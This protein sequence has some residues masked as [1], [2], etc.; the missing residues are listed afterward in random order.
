M[1]FNNTQEPD[2]WTSTIQNSTGAEAT[3]NFPLSELFP[4]IV[5]TSFQALGYKKNLK[6]THHRFLFSQQNLQ[7][8][9]LCNRTL[10]SDLGLWSII[11]H[12]RRHCR[13][14]PHKL[15]LSSLSFS[16]LAQN[17]P[18]S[19]PSKRIVMAKNTWK[20]TKLLPSFLQT[21]KGTDKSWCSPK[22]Q[23]PN[24]A[25]KYSLTGLEVNVKNGIVTCTIANLTME[26]PA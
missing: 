12:R 24:G 10:R 5:L 19:E 14:P 9:N 13:S 26:G 18:R 7:S 22:P 3:S 4:H 16:L 21:G 23:N 1:A 25:T 8:S 20:M 17:S 11:V 2:Q 15:K 6:K